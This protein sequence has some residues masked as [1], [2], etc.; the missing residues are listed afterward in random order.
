MKVAR[1]LVSSFFL[2]LIL[3]AHGQ[4]DKTRFDVGSL[5][6]G[7]YTNSYFG[8]KLRIPKSWQAIDE[9][10]KIRL[11]D[12]AVQAIG[13]D[14]DLQARKDVERARKTTT[15]NLLTLIRADSATLILG[16][17]K[18]GTGIKDSST[19]L[20]HL[21]NF[22]QRAKTNLSVGNVKSELINGR[23]FST[24][25]ATQRQDNLKVQQKTYVC[26][27]GEYMLLFIL[28]YVTEAQFN[29]MS[30]LLNSI[31]YR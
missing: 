12:A 20:S 18:V 23:K 17:E 26:L 2:I 6:N 29:E 30:I 22:Y 21:K 15:F 5:R 14:I 13:K 3:A 16:A 25:S 7:T 31:E 9:R 1:Y 10:G 8:L 11:E 28:S 24:L 27:D 19:Y 4:S